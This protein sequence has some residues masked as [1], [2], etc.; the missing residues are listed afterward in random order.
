MKNSKSTKRT[1]IG[2]MMS[3]VLCITMLLGTTLAWFTDTASTSVHKIESGKLKVALIDKVGN[4]LTEALTWVKAS[5]HEEEEILWEPGAEYHLPVFRIKNDGNL[6]LK[7]KLQIAGIEEGDEKLLEVLDF[8][9]K[10]GDQDVLDLSEEGHLA[11]GETSEPIT[12]SAKMQET[13]GNEYQGMTVNGIAITVIATQD[14]VENDSYGNTYDEKAAY[15]AAATGGVVKDGATVLQDK[16]SAYQVKITAPEGS[17]SDNVNTL[18]L[19][20]E[21][22]AT[23]SNITI[24]TGTKAVSAE[25]KLMDENGN[26]ITAADNKFFVLT[27]QI[28][29]NANVIGFYH[30]GVEVTKAESAEAVAAANDLYYYDAATGVVTFSTDDFSPFTVKVSDSAYNGGDGTEENPYLIATGEQAIAMRNGKGS[31]KLV[32]DVVVSNEIY[33]SGKKYALDL[34]GHSLTLEYEA[35]TKPNNG[36]VLNISGKSGKLTI[37]DSSEAQTGAVYGSTQ[38]YAN[39]VTSAVRVGNYGKLDIYGGHFYGRSAETSCIFVMTSTASSSKATVNIYGG[40]FETADASN[41]IYYVLNH[42]DSATTG[43][44]INVYG[45]QFKNYNPGVTV[46]DSVNAKTGKISLGAGCTTTTEAEGN[47]TWYVVGK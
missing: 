14:T 5:G 41:G 6:A 12:I 44:T 39:K 9:F 29:K 2:S 21:N 31:F 33:L 22:A 46:V 13:A 16:D 1:L 42:Q 34:N 30:N 17:V 32:K 26:K 18:T 8:T 35:G 27:M 19:T 28:E 7:Y 24:E 25:V 47:D 15:P 23:P 10:E 38:S 40:K 3:L 43:C 37:T 36:G 45:G 11:A 4:P 20:V